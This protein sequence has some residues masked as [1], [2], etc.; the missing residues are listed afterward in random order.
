MNYLGNTN[1]NIHIGDTFIKNGGLSVEGD[2]LVGGN[3]T[4]NEISVDELNV[5]GYKLPTIAGTDGQV[6]TMNPDRPVLATGGNRGMGTET[7]SELVA[8]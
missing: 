8:G 5:D 3:T 6:L 2:L 1:D 7:C 4:F